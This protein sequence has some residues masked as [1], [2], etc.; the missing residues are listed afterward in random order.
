MK[1]LFGER[2]IGLFEW[3]SPADVP[4]LSEGQVAILNR[5]IHWTSVYKKNGKLYEI[6][7]YNRDMLG[8]SFK[9]D[10]LPSSFKQPFNTADCG[11]RT[12]ALLI[13]R[14]L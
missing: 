10:K 14:V 3:R 5:Q 1:P 6:D 2:Y 12:I 9:D 8:A 4:K 13:K 11:S 7:S